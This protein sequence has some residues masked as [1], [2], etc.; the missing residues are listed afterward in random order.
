MKSPAQLIERWRRQWSVSS[1]RLERLLHPHAWPIALQIGLPSPR[2]FVEE[3]RA[4]RQHLSDWRTIDVG[5]V[6]WKPVKYREASQSVDMPHTWELRDSAEWAAACRDIGIENEERLLRSLLVETTPLWARDVLV[7]HITLFAELSREQI[8]QLFSVAEALHEGSA[9]GKPLRALSICGTDSKFIERHRT[10]LI[11][12]LDARFDGVVSDVGLEEFLSARRDSEHWLLVASLFNSSLPF[13]QMRVPAS[14][15]QQ[16]PL[17]CTHVLIVENEQAL[18][19]LPSIEGAIAILGAG[20]NLTW[21]TNSWLSSRHVAYWGDI[22]TW[23]LAM[24]SDAKSRLNKLTP[25]LMTREV[26]ELARSAAV[27]EPRTHGESMPPNLNLEE[28]S[29]YEFLLGHNLGRLEQEFLPAAVV[30]EAVLGWHAQNVGV[31]AI[32]K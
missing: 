5:K 31:E 18:H 22:D 23:G 8:R 7:R 16:I 30:K 29:L 1:T 14:S 13:P 21:L 27:C 17:P 26:Y 4:V 3:N 11:H 6:I 19:L 32:S 9:R 15:L 10:L 25:L 20:R 24:L 12:L 28:Q 2:E